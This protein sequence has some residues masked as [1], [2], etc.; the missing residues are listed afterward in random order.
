MNTKMIKILVFLTLSIFLLTIT[1]CHHHDVRQ[2][3]GHGNDAGLT[4][5]IVKELDLDSEQEIQLAEVLTSFEEK[6]EELGKRNELR[7]I[8]VEQLKS[9]EFD[10]DYLRQETVKLIRKLENVSNEIL[11]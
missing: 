4:S 1:A 8:F 9:R 3:S 10:Q 5:Y 11:S 6:K 2:Y 7:D